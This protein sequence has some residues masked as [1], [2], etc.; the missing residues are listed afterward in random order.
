[1]HVDLI[2]DK[3]SRLPELP[4]PESIT[5]LKVWHCGYGSLAP[6]YAL[7]NLRR[8]VIA[9]YPDSTFEPLRSLQWLEDLEILHFPHASSLAPLA[10]L[11][12]LR[13]L[14]LASLPSWDASSKRLKVESLAPIAALPRLEVLHLLGVVPPNNSLVELERSKSLREAR[15]HGYGK[16]ELERFFAATGIARASAA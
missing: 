9:S 4:S 12:G 6:I 2:R 13:S 1:M 3:A 11:L 16:S 8:L 15:I 7:P 10:M 5:S 14:R